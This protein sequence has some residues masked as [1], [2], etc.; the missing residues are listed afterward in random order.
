MTEI[1]NL[2]GDV[3]ES[4]LKSI[5]HLSKYQKTKRNNRYRKSDGTYKCNNC[6]HHYLYEYHDKI[7]HKCELIGVSNSEATDI[8]SGHVCDKWKEG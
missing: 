5:Q 6:Y 8:R 4:D 2:F 7:Y 1:I 3:V